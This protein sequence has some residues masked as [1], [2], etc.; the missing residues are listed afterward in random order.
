MTSEETERDEDN[1]DEYEED[2]DEKLWNKDEITLESLK[3]D[4]FRFC[5][6]NMV[7]DDELK[8]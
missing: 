3:I 1:E 8:D 4:I 6:I 5:N 2:D 7:S